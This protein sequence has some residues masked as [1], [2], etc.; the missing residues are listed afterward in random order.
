MLGLKKFGIVCSVGATI[1]LFAACTS[2]DNSVTPV[3][4]P[5]PVP[6]IIDD[7]TVVENPNTGTKDT[8]YQQ[9]E[10]R[11]DSLIQDI[12]ETGDTIWHIDTVYV[13]TDTTVRWVGNSALLMTEIVSIN[14]DWF[15]EDGDDPAWIELY[16]AGAEPIDLKGYYLV[17]TL[18][19][20]RKWS[21]GNEIIKPRSFRNV[22]ISK[23]NRMK[24]S[25]AKD[26]DN[27]H[28][29][30]HTNWK[31]EKEGGTVYLIDKFYGIRD[32][33][34]YPALESGMS[35]GRV[36]GGGWNYMSAP[37]PEAPNTSVPSYEGI[38]PDIDFGEYNG[39]F[40][41]SAITLNRP[42][43][44]DNVKIRCTK[45]GSAPT[46]N[47]EEMPAQMTIDSN[48]VL[49]CAAYEDGYLTKKVVTNTFFIGESVAMPVVA[50]T[51]DSAFFKKN[52]LKV[53]C[54]DPKECP[55]GLYEDVEYPVHV[56]YFEKGAKKKNW[57][58]E[59]GI[60]LMGNWSRTQNKKS[61]AIVMREQ[62]QNGRIN[63][64]LF[65]T[66]PNV[67]KYKAFNLRNNGNRFVSDYIGD[68]MGGEI[69]NGSG[70]DYQHSRQVVVFYDGRYYGIHDMRERFNEHYVESNYGV[71][72]KTVDI[73]KHLKDSLSVSGG[74][75]EG[76]K[77]LLS[78]VAQNDFTGDANE[79]YAMV[80]TMMDIGNF[81]DYMA[82]EIY[83]RNGDWPNN[84][85]RVW[86]SPDHP[87]KFMVYDL[88]HGFGWK[89][90][91]NN[92]EFDDNTNM[93][94]WIE[95]GGGN[96][97]CKKEGCFAN[98]Y[99]QLIQNPEFLRVF[100]HRSAAMWK[101]Y[102][103][104]DRISSVVKSMIA[105]IP[106]SEYKR[107]TEKFHQKE[108]GYPLGFDYEGDNFKSWA[109]ERD[110]SV[111]SEYKKQFDL[112][113]LV[114]VKIKSEGSGYVLM[115]GMVLP[116]KSDKNTDYSG[117]FFSGLPM[118]LEAVPAN[119]AVFAGWSDGESS[120]T[121]FVTVEDGVTFTA[122]FK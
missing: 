9:K 119:G 22:F 45:N 19:K 116:S 16:N 2:K 103:N 85:V 100:L 35:W 20:S 24:A 18:D 120:P 42:N 99:N 21:F 28:F 81:A 108:K 40:Y 107:D 91:V 104:S 122:N 7:T 44:G 61:V 94:E 38:V 33:V 31:L 97:P 71:D 32:S 47:S 36:D 117:K 68:A 112:E 58:I 26:V 46:A 63:Y 121:R 54:Q 82:T 41:S 84:N 69:L 111:V 98:L 96:K 23:K 59:A 67:T 34:T 66:N 4:N 101:S 83:I 77:Q 8:I 13:S 55:E 5:D 51:V 17:E 60:S 76:Y 86:R 50:V 29:R 52:Y 25:E 11:I 12:D 95:K 87:W 57:E 1:V 30:T 56:E 37:T 43:L 106:E 90:G 10:Q 110:N 15:D 89:W 27:K 79:N 118:L 115:E 62:Y 14:L 102:L 49:R 109:S 92:G 80:K 78:F 48:T 6:V 72:S 75:S 65:P 3:N 88:D 93:F 73:V 74:S 39:G 53:D 114:S 113:D 70:V 64:P 105:T